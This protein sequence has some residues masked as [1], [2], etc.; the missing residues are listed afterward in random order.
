MTLRTAFT[1]AAAAAAISLG[2]AAQA[3]NGMEVLGRTQEA[4]RFVNA[5]TRTGQTVLPRGSGQQLRPQLLHW[6]PF[7]AHREGPRRRSAQPL[8]RRDREAAHPGVET[9]ELARQRLL[10][11]VRHGTDRPQRMVSSN[12]RRA[13]DVAE[14]ALR[15]GVGAAHPSSSLPSNR[16]DSRT[17]PTRDVVEPVRAV[18]H[19]GTTRN[20]STP[21]SQDRTLRCDT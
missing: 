15:A 13:A 20:G 17:A 10:R 3:Q 16:T 18:Q 5:L 14:Q 6:L 11:L 19:G 2:G 7:R 4:S 8:L 12:L 21:S 9:L 1:A